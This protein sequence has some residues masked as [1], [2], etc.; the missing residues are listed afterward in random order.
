MRAKKSVVVGF[1]GACVA[2]FGLVTASA[3]AAA[4]PVIDVA[5]VAGDIIVEESTTCPSG[6]DPCWRQFEMESGAT[7]VC[8]YPTLDFNECVDFHVDDC[9]Y[10]DGYVDKMTSGQVVVFAT[11]V[12][13][14]E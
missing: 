2:C 7:V 9:I 3:V 12:K 11:A 4:D 1:V 5:I 14:C 13:L 10:V 8:Q 6:P